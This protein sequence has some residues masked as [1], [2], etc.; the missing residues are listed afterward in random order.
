MCVD[1]PLNTLLVTNCNAT[2]SDCED[3]V[4]ITI[5]YSP[6]ELV[7]VTEFIV[8]VVPEPPNWKV[9]PILGALVKPS[10]IKVVAEEKEP[11]VKGLPCGW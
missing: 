1:N 8:K 2:P 9:S 7:A 11:F 3:A 6:D 10:A 5:V 4:S